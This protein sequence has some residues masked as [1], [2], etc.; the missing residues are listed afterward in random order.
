MIGHYAF[1]RQ[2]NRWCGVLALISR[3]V[4]V[5]HRVLVLDTWYLLQ[6]WVTFQFQEV[7]EEAEARAIRRLI[8]ADPD[9]YPLRRGRPF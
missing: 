9:D 1:G 3:S 4:F 8:D 5:E 6:R 7:V 2:D